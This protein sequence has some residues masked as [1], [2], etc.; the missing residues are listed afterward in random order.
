[1]SISFGWG[2]KLQNI[3]SPASSYVSGND[4][5]EMYYVILLSHRIFS[6][7][8]ALSKV[9]QQMLTPGEGPKR[10]K[11]QTCEVAMQELVII[12]P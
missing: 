4:N 10:L 1:M 9:A 5:Q 2:K 6:F 12:Y 11:W 8:R 7:V 3:S